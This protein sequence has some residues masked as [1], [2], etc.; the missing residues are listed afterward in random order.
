[1]LHLPRIKDAQLSH[2]KRPRLRAIITDCVIDEGNVIG[3]MS[4]RPSASTLTLK[5]TV[6]ACATVQPQS[7]LGSDNNLKSRHE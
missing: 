3:R 1:M 5:R 4:V 2:R 7:Q 6:I